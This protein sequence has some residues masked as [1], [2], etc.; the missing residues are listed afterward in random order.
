[1]SIAHASVTV[2]TTAVDL[3]SGVPDTG[4]NATRSVILT[5]PGTAPVYLG[6]PGVTT[7]A[8]GYALAVGGELALDLAPGDA[9]FGIG[10]TAGGVVRVLHTGV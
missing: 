5:N 7:T 9:L 8:Y 3:T 10:A 2:D 1:M 4:G 6:G